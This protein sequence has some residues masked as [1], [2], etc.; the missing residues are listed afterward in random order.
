MHVKPSGPVGM[1]W[2]INIALKVAVL[3]KVIETVSWDWGPKAVLH[4][5][6]ASLS[7][8]V[9]VVSKSL[10]FAKGETF[11]ARS[12]FHGPNTH[13]EVA[14]DPLAGYSASLWNDGGE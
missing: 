3:Y 2:I 12:T 5:G 10:S 7:D 13:G 1:V 4:S 11:V 6:F 8:D 9:W 14:V